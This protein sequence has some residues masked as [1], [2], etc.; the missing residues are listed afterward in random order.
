MQ[1]TC[2]KANQNILLDERENYES[3]R[4]FLLSKNFYIITERFCASL[5]QDEKYAQF[6]NLY[7][8]FEGFLDVWAIPHL[9]LDIYSENTKYRK[10]WLE[11]KEFKELF[12]TFLIK[13]YN[14]TVS[15]EKLLNIDLSNPAVTDINILRLRKRQS[16]H[17]IIVDTFCKVIDHLSI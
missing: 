6:L 12:V 11:D 13:F 10:Q 3:T 14:Y 15:E 4:D 7:F 16:L 2:L 8:N 5:A 17:N 9:L 1:A